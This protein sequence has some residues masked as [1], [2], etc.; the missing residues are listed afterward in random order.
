MLQLAEALKHFLSDKARAFV[1]S[2]RQKP[3]L[4]S[5]ASDGTPLCHKVRKSIEVLG[6]KSTVQ[7]MT[8]AEFLVQ[9]VFLR[10]YDDSS[11]P[12]TTV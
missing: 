6:H 5:Y 9:Q 4:Y 1:L 10:Y 2:A 3:L 7:G 12:Q 8:S 11:K